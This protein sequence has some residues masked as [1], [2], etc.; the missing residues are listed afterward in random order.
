MPKLVGVCR[1]FH[2]HLLPELAPGKVHE[3]QRRDLLHNGKPVPPIIAA[4]T[5]RVGGSYS[6]V[7]RVR[8]NSA[9]CASGSYRLKELASRFHRSSLIRTYLRYL[10]CDSRC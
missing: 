3:D 5:L 2:R 1:C 6:K 4:S 10:E 9:E 7:I 8:F